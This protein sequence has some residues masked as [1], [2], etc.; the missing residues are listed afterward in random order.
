MVK[1]HPAPHP[2]AHAL[3]ID[4]AAA[5]IEHRP[6][7][8]YWIV[9]ESGHEAGPFRTRELAERDLQAADPAEVETDESLRE[10]EAEIGQDEW[11]DPDTGAPAEEARP[12]IEDR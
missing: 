10:A 4:P 5:R 1:P 6:D 11:I 9:A 3:P 8:F 12:R 2:R 7:G